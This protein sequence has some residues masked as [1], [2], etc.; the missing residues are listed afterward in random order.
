M[1]TPYDNDPQRPDLG[2]AEQR[3]GDVR[4]GDLRQDR[5]V[6]R[7]GHGGFIAGLVIAAILLILMVIFMSQNSASTTV[8]FF[9]WEGTV[10]LAVALL[11]AF[12]AGVLL[13]AIPGYLRVL[14]LKHR[15]RKL[16]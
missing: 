15:V 14:Q 7:G 3:A 4:E 8:S 12:V 16:R 1:S 9:G 11:V 13:V 5:A 2:R 10:S 6:E